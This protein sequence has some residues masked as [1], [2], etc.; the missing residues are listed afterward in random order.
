MGDFAA[1]INVSESYLSTVEH[2]R[3]EVGAAVLLSRS[4]KSLT[5]RWNGYSRARNKPV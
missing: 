3:K 1:R 4:V 2:G 5:S